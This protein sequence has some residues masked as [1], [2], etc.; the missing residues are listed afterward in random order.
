M[1]WAA[2]VSV[3]CFLEPDMY[4]ELKKLGNEVTSTDCACLA[5]HAYLQ[6]TSCVGEAMHHQRGYPPMAHA[7]P[8][9]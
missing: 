2:T 8:P 3:Y 4:A 1:A 9:L 5:S 7:R 6:K